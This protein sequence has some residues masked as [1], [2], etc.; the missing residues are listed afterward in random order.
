[1]DI[2]HLFDIPQGANPNAA[3]WGV[4]WNAGGAVNGPSLVNHMLKILTHI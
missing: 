4:G 2:N 3:E 1:M